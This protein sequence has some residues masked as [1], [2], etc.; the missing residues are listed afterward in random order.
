MNNYLAGELLTY[1][2]SYFHN[3]NIPSKSHLSANEIIFDRRNE[4]LA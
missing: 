3:G 2:K 4:A 1:K